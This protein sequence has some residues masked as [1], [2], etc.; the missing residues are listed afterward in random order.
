[1]P[2]DDGG[3]SHDISLCDTTGAVEW[4]NSAQLGISGI[5][6]KGI[7]NACTCCVQL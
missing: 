1:M 7:K 4:S 2:Y 3:F 5:Q 6:K